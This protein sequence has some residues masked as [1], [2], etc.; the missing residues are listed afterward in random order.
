MVFLIPQWI[1]LYTTTHRDSLKLGSRGHLILSPSSKD[2]PTTLG[3]DID[4][5]FA[6][7]EKDRKA[8]FQ[9]EKKKITAFRVRVGVFP[10]QE[11]NRVMVKAKTLQPVTLDPSAQ[12]RP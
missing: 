4:P 7:A 12:L 11:A 9:W 2:D 5:K 1:D 3:K 6:L 8:S 10:R